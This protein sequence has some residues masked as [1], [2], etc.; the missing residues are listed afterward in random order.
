MCLWLGVSTSG[1][2]HW[3]GCAQS[4]TSARRETLLV[5][6]HHYFEASDGTCGYR[7]IHADLVEEGTECY[8]ELVRHIMRDEGLIAC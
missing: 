2:Y 6:I 3:R 4:A 8:P 1:S 5:R 7:R